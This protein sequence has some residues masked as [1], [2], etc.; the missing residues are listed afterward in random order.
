MSPAHEQHVW[1]ERYKRTFAGLGW[2]EYELEQMAF[3]AW[4][5]W[6][7]GDPEETAEADLSYMMEDG[8]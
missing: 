5:S 8:E 6:G 7:D 2:S 3:N 1:M 4:E